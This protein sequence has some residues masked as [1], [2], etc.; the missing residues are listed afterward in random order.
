MSE[1]RPGMS[2]SAKSA[3]HSKL[4]KIADDLQLTNKFYAG[5]VEKKIFTWDKI[6]EIKVNG[7]YITIWQIRP[8]NDI[9]K[10]IHVKGHLS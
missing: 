4:R 7:L 8:V 2:R 6:D 5:L 3:L 1:R 9:H 10:H